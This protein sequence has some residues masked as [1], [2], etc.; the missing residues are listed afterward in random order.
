MITIHTYKEFEEYV[1]AFASDK[2]EFVI[3]ESRGGLGKSYTTR[4]TLI[5]GTYEAFRGYT[6]PLSLFK[7]AQSQPDKPFV[8]DDVDTLLNSKT[9]VALLKQITDTTK[10]NLVT[11]NTTEMREGE[12]VSKKRQF[13][14]RNNVLI[15]CNTL[16]KDDPN[17]SAL[18]TRAIHV[19][20]EPSNGEVLSQA[21]KFA[22]EEVY[23]FVE[24]LEGLAE[25]T[26][27]LRL[28]NKAKDLKSADMDW[29]KYVEQNVTREEKSDMDVL[30]D[31]LNRVD[32]DSDFLVKDAVSEF[33]D[34]TGK[35][36]RTFY[37]LKKEL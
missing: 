16:G 25:N 31:V 34:V 13:I 33:C 24:S 30:R 3:I 21:K 14:S 6:T 36:R 4:D 2:F 17:L 20:F 8:F 26:L 7:T 18:K 23:E 27:N 37:N 19:R 35:S 32:R 29:K 28:F 10:P 11:W 22:D 15:I 12:R 9:N 1:E 5:N